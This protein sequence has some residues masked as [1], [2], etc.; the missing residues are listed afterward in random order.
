MH[1]LEVSG[2][3]EGT[4]SDR[5]EEGDKGEE[6]EEGEEGDEDNHIKGAACRGHFLKICTKNW[7]FFTQLKHLT[8]NCH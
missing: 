8:H 1:L 5:G 2:E 7:R 6:G 4:K 3:G